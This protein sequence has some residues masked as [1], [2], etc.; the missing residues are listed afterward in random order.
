MTDHTEKLETTEFCDIDLDNLLDDTLKKEEFNK[1]TE[2]YIDIIA[3]LIGPET[4]N[5]MKKMED[6][7]KPIG[8][9][10]VEVYVDALKKKYETKKD[11]ENKMTSYP[12]SEKPLTPRERCD[13]VKKILSDAL[14]MLIQDPKLGDHLSTNEVIADFKDVMKKHPEVPSANEVVPLKSDEVKTS[15]R[16]PKDDDETVKNS[17]RCLKDDDNEVKVSPRVS[18]DEAVIVSNYSQ[19]VTLLDVMG[20]DATVVNAARVSLAASI[21]E[22]QELRAQDSRLI[23]FLSV[24]HHNSPFF[25]PMIRFRITM[26]IFIA[27][28][29]Y[30]HT[31]GF[32]RNEVSRRYVDIP[33][34][35]FLPEGARERHPSKKQGSKDVFVRANERCLGLLKESMENSIKSYRSLLNMGV[36]PEVARTVLPQSM[37]T[38]FI[39]TG[40]LAAYARLY[41]LRHSEDAQYE[42][43]RY[44]EEVGK[45]LEQRFPVSWRALTSSS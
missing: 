34:I 5:D 2:S 13:E 22:D 24:H 43:Q 42:I 14:T 4:Q 37:M 20:T 6:K 26:P 38:Q 27:R 18:K 41:N 16:A 7:L 17:P 44:A 19:Y 8:E 32:A 39:E 35:C 3:T 25:H 29:W 40:S 15:P 36:A 11:D 12:V 21:D 31:V 10:I 45:V 33:V 30:R 28:E 1:D 23:K 9:K